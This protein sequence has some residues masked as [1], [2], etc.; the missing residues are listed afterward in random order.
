MLALLVC[1]VIGG[2]IALASGAN[3]F[4]EAW[5]APNPR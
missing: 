3:S 1:D 4:S 5:G 2:F